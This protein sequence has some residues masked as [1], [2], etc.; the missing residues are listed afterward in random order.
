MGDEPLGTFQCL[1]DRKQQRDHCERAFLWFGLGQGLVI[2][3]LS[4]F[5]KAPRAGEAPKAARK[6]SQSSRDYAPVEMLKT[7]IFW[8]ISVMMSLKSTSGLMVTSQMA[9]FGANVGI[10]Q[11]MGSAWRASRWR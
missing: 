9:T 11:S 1:L 8:L 2:L 6:L 5:L 7:P 10:T 3:V 4:Q